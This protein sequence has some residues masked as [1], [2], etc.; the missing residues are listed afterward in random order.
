MSGAAVRRCTL[1]LIVGIL[2]LQSSVQNN[3]RQCGIRC[4]TCSRNKAAALLPCDD[5]ASDYMIRY[6]H[7][8]DCGRE[9]DVAGARPAVRRYGDVY[10]L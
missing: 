6:C 7:D 8:G 5:C 2:F 9:E 3:C 1:N 4:R 10:S